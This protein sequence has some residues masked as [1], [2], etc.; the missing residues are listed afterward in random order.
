[1]L[2]GSGAHWVLLTDP[3]DEQVVQEIWDVLAMPATSGAGVLERVTAVVEKAFE[4][5]PPALAAVDFTSGASSRY[6]TRIE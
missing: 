3:G 4:G 2:V 1:M 6:W 5:D